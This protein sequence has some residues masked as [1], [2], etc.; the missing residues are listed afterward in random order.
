MVSVQNTKKFFYSSYIL[1]HNQSNFL[2]K[3]PYKIFLLSESALTVSFGQ[4]ID[5]HLNEYLVQL[6]KEMERKPFIG[7]QE[8]VVT[9]ASLTVYYDA[10]SI[11]ENTESSPSEFVKLYAEDLIERFD[12]NPQLESTKNITEIPVI[13][14]GEDFAYVCSK[15]GLTKTKLI[16]LHTAPLYRV[17]MMGFLPGFAYLGGMDKR[18]TI[19]R[20]DSPRLKV[21]TGSVGIAGEQT[22]VYPVESPGGWQ[23]IGRTEMP[24]FTP[25]KESIT[26][27][28][29][30]D[31]VRFA[32][33]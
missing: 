2:L 24:L 22:G 21:P 13:Y 4:T 30:G 1:K 16:E 14:D 9:Y 7:L 17:Y 8:V 33:I 6:G 11:H 29:Q 31:Y 26:L 27:L 5:E 19:P 10:F 18:L 28:K 32:A 20:R 25:D 3:P 12:L 23:L 15:T